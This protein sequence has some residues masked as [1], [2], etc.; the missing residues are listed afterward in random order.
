MSHSS[1]LSDSSATTS[2]G[3]STSLCENHVCAHELSDDY[4]RAKRFSAAGHHVCVPS[5][6]PHGNEDDLIE[7]NM[8]PGLCKE[9]LPAQ[10]PPYADVKHNLDATESALP[11]DCQEWVFTLYDFDGKGKVSRDDIMSLV[12]SIYEVLGNAKL[13]IHRVSNKDSLRNGY[14]VGAFKIK[15]S[16]V[17]DVAPD[18]ENLAHKAEPKIS[19]FLTSSGNSIA[20]QS[21]EQKREQDT[22]NPSQLKKGSKFHVLKESNQHHSSQKAARR[23]VVSF[24]PTCMPNPKPCMSCTYR[25]Y[26]NLS[27][28]ENCC[29]NKH[30]CSTSVVHHI[31]HCDRHCHCPPLFQFTRYVPVQSFYE[32]AKPHD[33]ANVNY[34]SFQAVPL[35]CKSI[36]RTK[37]AAAA[38]AAASFPQKSS[39]GKS[40]LSKLNHGHGSQVLRGNLSTSSQIFSVNEC[41]K[42]TERHNVARMRCFEHAGL[43]HMSHSFVDDS[44]RVVIEHQHYHEHHHYHH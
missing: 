16:V 9:T 35:C 12:R 36:D 28:L 3:S 33:I 23:K 39:A 37:C 4:E 44:D 22:C 17:P 42:R 18:P 41:K 7:I 14:P 30:D 11:S 21:K 31:R 34:D 40:F 1:D 15:L 13:P 8:H 32:R 5:A 6:D 27:E 25:D 38:A 26:V 2:G 19:H 43:N 20:D 24:S 10:A 29:S